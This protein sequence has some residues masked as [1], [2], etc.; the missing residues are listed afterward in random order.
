MAVLKARQGLPDLRD[1][2]VTKATLASR[3]QP[4]RLAHQVKRVRAALPGQLVREGRQDQPAPKAKRVQVQ[5][6]VSF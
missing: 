3:D 4:V 5:A 1:Q 6:E 2:R